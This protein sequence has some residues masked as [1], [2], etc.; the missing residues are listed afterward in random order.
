MHSWLK[1]KRKDRSYG[2]GFFL[3]LSKKCVTLTKKLKKPKKLN[4]NQETKKCKPFLLLEKPL[5]YQK[6]THIQKF[7]P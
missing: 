2:T 7:F 6:N 5:I 4:R 3:C 1:N